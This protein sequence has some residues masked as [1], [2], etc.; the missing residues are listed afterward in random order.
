[1]QSLYP[2]FISFLL[3]FL[4]EL[5]DKTQILVLSFSSKL[6]TITI[7]IGV[8]LGSFFSHGIAI[9]F[10]SFLGNTESL[11]LHKIL[12]FV[13]YASFILIG[14]L[15]F[16]PK[17]NEKLE[18][19][20]SILGKISKFQFNYMFII[21]F[22]IAVGEFGDKTFL[23]SIGLGIEYPF[24]KLALIIGAILGMC[25][26]DLIAIVLGKFLSTKIPARK[27]ETL[28]SI[29][30]LLFGIIGFIRFFV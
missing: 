26:S 10:G 28:S 13:T 6:K 24:A 9:L 20:N 3:I 11:I 21:A 22:S 17:K 12:E 18:S 5:G 1:M 8:A 23:A 14:L 4:S 30:F 29:L 15:S 2:L 27:I 7:L 19:K 16:L 25:A